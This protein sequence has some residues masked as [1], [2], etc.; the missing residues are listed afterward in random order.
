MLV[1]NVSKQL[2]KNLIEHYQPLTVAVHLQH[3]AKASHLLT[4]PKDDSE[5]LEDFS[6]VDGTTTTT[7]LSE[8]IKR[9]DGGV[10]SVE[11]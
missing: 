9:Y 6:F 8:F 1:M 5:I 7:T 11:V 10:I 3:G 2:L 4:M